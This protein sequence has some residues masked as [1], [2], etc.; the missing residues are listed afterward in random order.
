SGIAYA[1]V[2]AGVFI[3]AFYSFRLYFVVFHGRERIDPYAREH[4]HESPWVVTV[5]LVLLAV[6]SLISGYFTIGPLLFGGFFDGAIRVLPQHDVVGQLGHEFHGP[7]AFALHGFLAPAFWLAAAG[8]GAAWYLYLHDPALAQRLGRRFAAVHRVLERKYGFD[9]FNQ[10]FF[11]AGSRRV[12]GALWK[13][14]DAG[15]IDGLL[16]NGTAR[17]VGWAAGVVRQVQSGYLYHYAFA[18]LIGL[19]ALLTWFVTP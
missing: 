17:M 14:G 9:E 12:G 11:A 19:L 3:T 16:V 18:M 2:L 6:P 7:L 15:L 10:A 5:P 8:V 13:Y 4:L 1:A